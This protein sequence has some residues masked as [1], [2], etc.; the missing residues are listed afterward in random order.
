[1]KCE[2]CTLKAMD[3]YTLHKQAHKAQTI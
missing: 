1:M 3:K 2:M